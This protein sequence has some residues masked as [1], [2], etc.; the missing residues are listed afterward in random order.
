MSSVIDGSYTT[1]Y[2]PN[3]KLEPPEGKKWIYPAGTKAPPI[4]KGK[5]WGDVEPTG[6]VVHRDEFWFGEYFIQYSKPHIDPPRARVVG[7]FGGYPRNF[8]L[9]WNGHEFH[10]SNKK[11]AQTMPFPEEIHRLAKAAYE[12]LEHGRAV[13]LHAEKDEEKSV[14]GP[15][16]AQLKSE[17][18]HGKEITSR[19]R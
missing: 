15:M 11:T 17:R 8:T 4:R 10:Y 19:A 6:I 14:V 3:R 12:G 5:V 2:D 7:V 16:T 9:E 1:N 18:A 13:V